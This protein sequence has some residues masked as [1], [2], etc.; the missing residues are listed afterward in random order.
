MT[1]LREVVP[2]SELREGDVV[3]NHGMRL[4]LGPVHVYDEFPRLPVYASV[5][6]VENEEEAVAQGTVPRSWMHRDVFVNGR[7]TRSPEAT[8]T[9]QGNELARWTREVRS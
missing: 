9:V 1:A 8:W 3:F 6:V 4:R 2:T 7:W 5:A